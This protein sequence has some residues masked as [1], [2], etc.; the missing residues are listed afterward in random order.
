MHTPLLPVKGQTAA[1][2]PEGAPGI[3]KPTPITSPQLQV[4]NQLVTLSFYTAHITLPTHSSNLGASVSEGGPIIDSMSEVAGQ[5]MT[6]ICWSVYLKA[7]YILLH[8]FLFF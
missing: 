8:F 1:P 5:Q 3:C 6:N 7:D 4:M 2:P